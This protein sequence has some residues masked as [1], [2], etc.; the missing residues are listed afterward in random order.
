MWMWMPARGEMF[1]MRWS[2]CVDADACKGRDVYYEVVQLC[3]CGCLQGERCL[4]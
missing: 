3:G 4:L 1:I 2:S